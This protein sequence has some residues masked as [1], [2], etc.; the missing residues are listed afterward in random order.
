[1]LCQELLYLHVH[2]SFLPAAGA[3]VTGGATATTAPFGKE[4]VDLAHADARFPPDWR[5]TL[6]Y[7]GQQQP[8]A[9][10]ATLVVGSEAA[11]VTSPGQ[12]SAVA[13]PEHG[14]A[15]DPSG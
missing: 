7:R 10:G 12:S 1:M 5:L 4:E 9:A 14:G 3:T 8:V 2:T 13:Q 15:P 6:H 11:G